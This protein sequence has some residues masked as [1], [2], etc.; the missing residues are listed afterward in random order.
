MLDRPIPECA[1]KE[2]R[3][4][5]SDGSTRGLRTPELTS[6][7]RAAMEAKQQEEALARAQQRPTLLDPSHRPARGVAMAGQ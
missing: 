1:S 4:L 5:N 3:I 2:Q 7:E 6:D